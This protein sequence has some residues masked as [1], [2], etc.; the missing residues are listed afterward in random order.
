MSA[1]SRNEAVVDLFARYYKIVYHQCLVKLHFDSRFTHLVD[2]CIQEAFVIF[3]IS[4]DKLCDHPNPAGWLCNTA[5]NRLRSEIRK[6]NRHLQKLSEIAEMEK[7]A[8]SE[9][10]AALERWADQDIALETVAAICSILTQKEQTIYQSYYVEDLSLAE[11]ARKNDL[12][13]NAVR[14]AISRIK[15]RAKQYE[16]FSFFL[17]IIECILQ[18]SRTK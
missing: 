17:F 14:S 16:Q 5:W 13:P 6:T 10:E 4:Y 11:T 8:P 1:I 9:M 12:S 2:D 3:L 15:K 18:I 7:G